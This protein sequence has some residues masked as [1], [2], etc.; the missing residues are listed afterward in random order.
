MG[1]NQVGSA[2]QPVCDSDVKG[3]R[4]LGGLAWDEAEKEAG[5]VPGW[6]PWGRGRPCGGWAWAGG[7]GHRGAARGGV[8]SV[9]SL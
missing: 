6:R 7:R 5:A 8:G 3:L 1:P 9:S 2:L 4:P